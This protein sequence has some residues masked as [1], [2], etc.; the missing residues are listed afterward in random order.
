MSTTVTEAT[1]TREVLESDV[2]VL[3]DFWAPWC[4]PCRAV[5]PILET[6]AE[7]HGLKLVKVNYDDEPRL[8]ERFDIQAIPNMILFRDGRPAAQVLGARPKPALA[9]AFGLMS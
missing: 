8:A 4:A 9:A 1:F 6:L 7:E 3:V 2:P 5:G